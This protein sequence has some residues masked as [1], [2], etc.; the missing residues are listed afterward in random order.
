MRPC[1]AA[2]T[3]SEGLMPAGAFP[4]GVPFWQVRP[5]TRP[6]IGSVLGLD[7]LQGAGS[8][9][10]P[11]SEPLIQFNLLLPAAAWTFV[12]LFSTQQREKLVARWLFS[13]LPISPSSSPETAPLSGFS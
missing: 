9:V 7:W 4:G 3:C 8:S 12:V 6:L 1:R 2:T 10:T 13:A 11:F 5:L